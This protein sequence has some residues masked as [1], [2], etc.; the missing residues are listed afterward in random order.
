[1]KTR[2]QTSFAL[3]YGAMLGMAGVIV[4]LVFYFLG[5][6]PSSKIPGYIGYLISIVTIAYGIKN[7][8]DEESGGFI[9]YGRSLGT[10]V[11]IGLFGAIITAIFTVLMFTVID[12]D[13]AQRMLEIG[14]Q[15]MAEKGMSEEQMEMA[16]TYS[17]KFMSPPFL[18]IF[19]LLSSVF[20]SFIFSLIISI[21][22]KKDKDPFAE[23]TTDT[24]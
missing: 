10:G 4:Y 2:S 14:Q 6:D 15:K 7:Y 5:A 17:K 12:P 3:T 20:M 9:S 21:F 16:M 8:R 23:K 11:L 19:A 1:M 22:M 24:I 18:F 13:L